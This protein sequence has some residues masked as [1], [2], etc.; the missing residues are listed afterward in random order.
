M[1]KR[2]GEKAIFRQ[3]DRQRQRKTE[4]IRDG[5]KEVDNHSVKRNSQTDG[6]TEAERTRQRQI[7][8]KKKKSN[9]QKK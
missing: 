2:E 5:K 1:K 9:R 6:Q 7:K 8:E 3:T 4:R